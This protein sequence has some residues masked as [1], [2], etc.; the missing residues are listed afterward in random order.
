M[1]V[2]VLHMCGIMYY[3]GENEN[4]GRKFSMEDPSIRVILII[5]PKIPKSSASNK[6]INESSSGGKLRM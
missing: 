1:A 6:S 2:Y 5:K 4:E 3:G